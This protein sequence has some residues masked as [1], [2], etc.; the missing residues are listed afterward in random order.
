MDT[1]TGNVTLEAFAARVDCHFTTASRLRAGQRMPGR[2]LLGRIVEE[3]SLDPEE[4]L[5]LFTSGTPQQFGE[6]LREDVFEV[7]SVQA[8]S[9][10]TGA[11]NTSSK[12]PTQH[13][14]SE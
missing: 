6:Y 1:S 7:E 5:N 11:T 14:A 8:G 10:E 13:A 12:Q 4:A 3:Y 9:A 2:E